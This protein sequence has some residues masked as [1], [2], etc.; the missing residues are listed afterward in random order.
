[1]LSIVAIFAE[2]AQYETQIA[3]LNP[4]PGAS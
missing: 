1:M 3:Y 4:I 2:I